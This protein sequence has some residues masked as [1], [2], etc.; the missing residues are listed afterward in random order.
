MSSTPIVI[1]EQDR[2]VCRSYYV[3]L[4]SKNI[5]TPQVDFYKPAHCCKV[6]NEVLAL[7]YPNPQTRQQFIQS[8]VLTCTGTL[9]PDIEFEWLKNN[10]HACYW[11]WTYLRSA[12]N[13]M[14]NNYYITDNT[15]TNELTDY[16]KLG[17]NTSPVNTQHRY[18]LIIDFFDSWYAPLN[19]KTSL[20]K[21]L[22]S[23]WEAINVKPK[24]F[25]WLDIND[26]E[27]CK[28]VWNY[29]SE[30]QKPKL[31]YTLAYSDKMKI[32]TFY[33][34][35]SNI[36]EIKLAIYVAVNLWRAHPDTKKLFFKD[37]NKAFSQKKHR[38]K[39]ADS[40]P[41]NTY[42]KIETKKRLNE[43]ARRQDKKIVDIIDSL[44][45]QAYDTLPPEQ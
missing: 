7:A 16:E 13:G 19:Y 4:L 14:L 9:I 11:L 3:Y 10:E 8:M 27:Q 26:D 39:K 6:F 24:P 31:A 36:D 35:P 5:N 28:W 15:V 37:I 23:E 20:L 17:L 40:K 2:R 22:E 41:F 29:I 33:L 1:K 30:A 44:I 45:N 34:H 32:P 25:K 38:I 42:L 21:K 18:N 12:D 43:I